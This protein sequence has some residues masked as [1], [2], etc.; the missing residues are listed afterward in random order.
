MIKGTTKNIALNP[1]SYKEL[2][3]E[4]TLAPYQIDLRNGYF[5]DAGNY[6]K[7]P[8]YAEK[9]D[10]GT[11]KAV[12]LLIPENIGYAVT[13]DGRIFRLDFSPTEFTGKTLSGGNRP[14]WES[15]NDIIIICDGGNPV[16]IENGDTDF[17][18]GNP[19]FAK[20][21]ARV[22]DYTIMA[23]HD[24]TEIKWSNAGNPE[25]WSS[26]TAG[27]NTIKLTGER[28]RNIK[29][30]K[31]KL[32]VFK[33]NS[34]ETW[35]YRN[36]TLLFTRQDGL[37]INKGCG[38]DYSVVEAN[39]TYYWFG[40]DGDFYTLGEFS[41]EV[42]SR[43]YRAELDKLKRPDSIY[44]FDFRK[45]NLIRWYAPHDG[46]C[47]VYDYANKLF[48]EDNVWNHGQWERMPINSYMELGGEQYIGDY[49]PTGKIYH[50][51]KDYKDDNG[52]PIRV[53][54]KFSLLL[55]NNGHNSRV[56]H[57]RFRV[58]RGV[59][60]GSVTDPK[61]MFRYRFDKQ[62]WSNY[63][64]FDL[65]TSPKTVDGYD[66]WLDSYVLGIGRE[67]EVEVV[68]TDAVDYVLTHIFMTAKE[69]GK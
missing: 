46:R 4:E 62:S 55:S 69:L 16:K 56:N 42:I 32:L 7:R 45:E 29:S 10:L 65:D 67:M 5:S 13:E 33:D 47:F 21:I 28:I 24:D 19:P 1:V 44:G 50:W 49:N 36:E 59:G 40:N 61:L 53:Y 23:G 11:D 34:I 54:R 35:I 51:S 48:W 26:G 52:N 15:H 20:Y 12:T 17:L 14:T 25:E 30:Y 27:F 63:E 60:D 39:N 18:G 64:S 68:E 9:W 38:A 57:L 66:M 8:G 6:V 2:N 22:L 58:K 43:S 31:E 3:P 41:P 37:W